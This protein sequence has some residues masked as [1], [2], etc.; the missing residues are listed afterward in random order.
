MP[1]YHKGEN[2]SNVSKSLCYFQST[3]SRGEEAVASVLLTG[4]MIRHWR[5]NVNTFFEKISSGGEQGKVIFGYI[6]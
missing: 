2:K 3:S 6:M 1:R 4:I 5:E